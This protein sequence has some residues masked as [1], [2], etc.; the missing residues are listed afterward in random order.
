MSERFFVKRHARNE[1]VSGAGKQTLN[2]IDPFTGG[3]ISIVRQARV[4]RITQAAVA[5]GWCIQMMK[6]INKLTTAVVTWC[7][8]L[9]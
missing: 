5:C 9:N 3:K 1:P 2:T 4:I 6:K 7:Q 8:E